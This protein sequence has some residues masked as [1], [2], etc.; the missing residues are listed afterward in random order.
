M[1]NIKLQKSHIHR[2]YPFRNQ[3]LKEKYL[4]YYNK[5]AKDWPVPSKTLMVETSYGSTFVRISGLEN[6]SVL[7]L[8][9]GDTE[10]SLSWIHQI[11]TL[12][13]KYRLYTPD[14]VFDYGLSI[15]TRPIKNVEDILN[16]LEELFTALELNNIN[17]LGFSYGGWYATLYA[18]KHPER[19]NKMI[20]LAPARTVLSG[21]IK[22]K[23]HAIYQHLFPTPRI[24]K[25]YIYWSY[26]DTAKKN[27]TTRAIL[28]NMI[29]ELLLSIKCFKSRKFIIPTVLKTEEWQ[30][31]KTPTLFVVG[32]NEFIYSAQE[33][34]KLLNDIAPEIKTILIP[35]AGH[36]LIIVETERVNKEV[37][38][39]LANST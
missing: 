32:K 16:W 27:D 5:K 7:V 11:K 1:N 35:D 10:N 38:N 2:F 12:S 39:F 25:K 6:S 17:L 26:A 13:K 23:I 19:L 18:I 20:L 4:S 28:D 31:L 30:T 15:D 14:P 34:V 3:A 8:L 37:L 21:K 22:A 9:P 24:I 29:N 36:D 33:A